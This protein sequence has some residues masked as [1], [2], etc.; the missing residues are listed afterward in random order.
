MKRHLIS[1]AITFFTAFAVVVLSQIDSITI[2]TVQSGAVAGIIFAALRA[3]IKALLE[4]FVA[5]Y[6]NRA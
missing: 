6:A 5:S 1:G 2:E 3:G 4:L